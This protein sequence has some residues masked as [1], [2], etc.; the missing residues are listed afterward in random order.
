MAAI[1]HRVIARVD[2]ADAPL[3]V[4]IDCRA[5]VFRAVVAGRHAARTPRASPHG[6]VYGVPAT[7][8][9]DSVA[10]TTKRRAS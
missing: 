6:W 8:A 1:K 7:T 9:R 2:S 10:R 5:M 3:M 4:R